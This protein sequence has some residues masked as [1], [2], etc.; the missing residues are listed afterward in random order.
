MLYEKKKIIK[1]AVS[2]LGGGGAVY[3]ICKIIDYCINFLKSLNDS[4][5]ILLFIFLVLVFFVK[6]LVI[7]HNKTKIELSKINAESEAEKQRWEK[8]KELH[9]NELKCNKK[10]DEK[11]IA[12][13]N[14]KKVSESLF[15]RLVNTDKKETEDTEKIEDKQEVERKAY[16]AK[17]VNIFEY[18]SNKIK[19]E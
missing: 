8:F 16:F 17:I 5:V 1:F 12:R 2:I 6:P 13:N 14:L 3:V 15:D 7:D 18:L 10:A 19:N 9:D 4:E 11:T